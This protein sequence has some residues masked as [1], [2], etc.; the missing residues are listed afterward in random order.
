MIYNN[1]V[2]GIF[3][4]RPN[5]FVAHVMVNNKEEIAHVKNTGR[6]RE[7]LIPGAT[8]FLEDHTENM[9]KRK[10]RY[11]LVAAE[12]EDPCIKMGFR[13]INIDSQAPN[14]VV[15]EAL[16]SGRIKL[17]DFKGSI[18]LLKAEQTFRKSRFDFY[19][20]SS[21][22]EKAF[23]EVK[24]VTLEIDGIARF[25]D[26]PTIRGVK[27]I[28]ELMQAVGKGFKAFTIFVIQMKDVK[29]FEPNNVTHEAFGK[30]LRDA[31]EVGVHILAYD[32]NV[33]KDTM[34]LG[35]SVII[36]L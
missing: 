29:Y 14:T 33:T 20:E 3:I 31:E 2:E 1:I 12:K 13:L 5:R 11:S 30:A 9:G 28:Y 15:G 32:C 23:L 17:P 6:C 18:S 7:I 26:A 22:G 16:K 8:V 34:S 24:G 19:L 25:P 4:S 27:H 36:R 10:T 35:E 21:K